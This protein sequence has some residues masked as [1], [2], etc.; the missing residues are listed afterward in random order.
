[1]GCGNSSPAM[2]TSNNN[3]SSSTAGETHSE[4]ISA[5]NSCFSGITLD[6]KPS[7]PFQ[8]F[9]LSTHAV[10]VIF[11]SAQITHW[12]W[13]IWFLGSEQFQGCKY[14]GFMTLVR[15]SLHVSVCDLRSCWDFIKGVSFTSAT[16]YRDA[17]MLKRV[18]APQLTSVH[19]FMCVLTDQRTLGQRTTNG[20]ESDCGITHLACIETA[21]PTCLM[22]VQELWRRLCG[23][24]YR[25]EQHSSS[26]DRITQR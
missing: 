8:N 14:I 17:L 15:V 22:S 4:V 9:F 12:F 20:S 13:L 7:E 6:L 3:S 5:W 25:P 10:K 24:S 16:I 19:A 26:P 18:S 2:T 1:M 21:S 23:F 11:S